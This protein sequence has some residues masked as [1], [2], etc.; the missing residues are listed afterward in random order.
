MALYQDIHA[1]LL[2]HET[3][4]LCEASGLPC[5]LDFALRPVWPAAAV[6]G[7]AYPVRCA[8]GDNLGIHIALDA[9]PP[10]HVLVADAFGY[11]AGYWGEVLTV[12]AQAKQVLGLV[13]DGGVRD[14]AALERRKFPVF[15]RGIGMRGTVKHHAR[16]VGEPIVVAGVLIA[17][18]DLIV[19]DADGVLSLPQ[20]HVTRT[21]EGA[22]KRTEKEAG[23]MRRLQKGETTLELLGLTAH[24]KR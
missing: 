11:I 5:A 3:S 9:M 4:T 22:R 14:I 19:A 12:G 10:G 8:P 18:G 1:E 17:P 16:S 6:A 24:R 13:I 15:S 23:S 7:P 2:E 21:L 20:A